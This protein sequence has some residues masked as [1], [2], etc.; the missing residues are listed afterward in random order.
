SPIASSTTAPA[1]QTQIGTP[2][3]AGCEDACPVGCVQRTEGHIGCV[4]RTEGHIGA[5]GRSGAVPIDD[6]P[7]CDTLNR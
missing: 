5:L 6:R 2:L 1:I 7:T 3:D 4:E